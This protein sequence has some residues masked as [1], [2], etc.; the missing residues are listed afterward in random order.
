M[1]P[2]SKKEYVEAVFMRYKQSTRKKKI[3][4]LDELCATCGYH[5]KYA[6][7]LLRRFKRF[8]KQKREEAV[9]NPLFQL[10]R[11]SG[12]EGFAGQKPF[13]IKHHP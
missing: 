10:A 5:R 3:L 9:P 12:F 8:T 7:Q 4:I 2:R 11:L 6:I 1:S 13:I